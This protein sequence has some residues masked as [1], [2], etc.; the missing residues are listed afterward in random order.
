MSNAEVGERYSLVVDCSGSEVGSCVG[1]ELGSEVGSCVGSELGED[2]SGTLD[3]SCAESSSGRESDE[4][5]VSKEKS[6]LE[7][8]AKKKFSKPSLKVICVRDVY[9]MCIVH[10][11]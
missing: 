6:V 8:Q 5:S 1:S 7:V 3:A 9:L 2:G 4:I 11:I 10:T